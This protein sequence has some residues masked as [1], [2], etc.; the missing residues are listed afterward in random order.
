MRPFRSLGENYGKRFSRTRRILLFLDLWTSQQLASELDYA[1]RRR[2]A[3]SPE[4]FLYST[5]SKLSFFTLLLLTPPT[6]VG[7]VFPS[8]CIVTPS[9][10]PSSVKNFRRKE[11]DKFGQESSVELPVPYSMYEQKFSHYSLIPQFVQNF[12][13]APRLPRLF[14][15][16][17]TRPG[18]EWITG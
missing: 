12:R 10:V 6:S 13:G 11:D 17:S 16:C 15:R 1:R 18:R 8:R 2:N 9:C 4:F 3:S 7:S 14:P 5:R